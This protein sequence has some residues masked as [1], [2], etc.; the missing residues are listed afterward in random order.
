MAPFL[1]P[2]IFN[3]GL[4]IWR[5]NSFLHPSFLVVVIVCG[6]VG[7]VLTLLAHLLMKS[8]RGRVEDKL[9]KLKKLQKFEAQLK[10]NN[11]PLVWIKDKDAPEGFEG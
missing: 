4:L 7:V 5:C 2:L 10:A 11:E 3:L 6:V 9:V 8:R 1:A